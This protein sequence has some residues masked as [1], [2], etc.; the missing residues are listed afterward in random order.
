MV[1]SLEIAIL[2]VLSLSSFWVSTF[3]FHPNFK[4]FKVGLYDEKKHHI[5]FAPDFLVTY[6]CSN[7][8]VLEGLSIEK[9]KE[10]VEVNYGGYGRR[11]GFRT[12]KCLTK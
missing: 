4:S 3:L 2:S 7:Y 10:T 8:V 9:I 11:K 12:F 5:E 1:Y 6:S